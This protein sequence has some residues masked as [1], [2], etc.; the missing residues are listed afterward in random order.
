VEAAC[1][2]AAHGEMEVNPKPAPRASRIKEVA[3]ATNA[4]AM[5]A[6]HETAEA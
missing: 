5:I 3:A 4:P 2:L 1:T 6:G